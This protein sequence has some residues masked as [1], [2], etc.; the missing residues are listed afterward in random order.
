MNA[1]TKKALMLLA[2]LNELA[3]EAPRYVVDIMINVFGHTK[4]VSISIYANCSKEMYLEGKH[5][6]PVIAVT[7]QLTDEQAELLIGSA[8]DEA[9][10]LIGEHNAASEQ[11]S[12][13]KAA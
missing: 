7:F 8:I 2:E 4:A 3:I 13:D 11:I 1:P 9:N 6:T 5:R 12:A 10:Q